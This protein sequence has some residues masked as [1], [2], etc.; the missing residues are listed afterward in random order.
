MPAAIDFSTWVAA[1]RREDRTI[2]AISEGFPGTLE[3]SLDR[4]PKCQGNWT[5]YVAGVA[6]TLEAAGHRLRGGNLL[7]HGEIPVGSGL[8]SSPDAGLPLA[9]ASR[10]A[11]A[12]GGKLGYL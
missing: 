7:I 2:R 11:V 12:S 4:T 3:F 5:D 9:H 8:S 10:R 1:G 6:A